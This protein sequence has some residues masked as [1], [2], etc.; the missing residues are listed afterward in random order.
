MQKKTGKKGDARGGNSDV[1]NK[2]VGAQGSYLN[3]C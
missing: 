3:L 1:W 2:G